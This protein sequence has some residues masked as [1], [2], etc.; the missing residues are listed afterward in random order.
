MKQYQTSGTRRNPKV[1]SS[2][3]FGVGGV[4]SRTESREK[5]PLNKSSMTR[6]ISATEEAANAAPLQPNQPAV[7]TMKKGQIAQPIL[8][9]MLCQ[10]KA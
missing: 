7:V 6:T 9:V 3:S 1:P 8:P 2:F 5:T 10:A 4:V